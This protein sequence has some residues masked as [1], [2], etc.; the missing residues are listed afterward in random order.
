MGAVAEVLKAVEGEGWISL[1]E[2]YLSP[3]VRTLFSLNTVAVV[4]L[5]GGKLQIRP[6][7]PEDKHPFA[8]PF[9]LSVYSMRWGIGGEKVSLGLGRIF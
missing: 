2:E 8:Q 4:Y 9:F 6:R 3:P 5:V 7:R 1:V